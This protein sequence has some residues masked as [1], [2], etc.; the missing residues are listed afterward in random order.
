MHTFFHGW[1]RKAG[2][3]LLS[4]AVLMCGVWGASTKFGAL[5]MYDCSEWQYYCDSFSDS[6]SV[7]SRS[8]PF[9]VVSVD[10]CIKP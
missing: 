2:F 5:A 6:F 10:S 1:R 7:R 8:L 3:G 4:S 9:G